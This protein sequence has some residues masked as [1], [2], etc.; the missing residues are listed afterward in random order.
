M[1]YGIFVIVMVFPMQYKATK[2]ANILK[3]KKKTNSD[4]GGVLIVYNNFD[5]FAPCVFI[6][7][8]T[9]KKKCSTTHHRSQYVCEEHNSII[10][11]HIQ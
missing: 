6:A 7:N 8:M 1:K 4:E 9:G 11:F 2:S 3:K 5:G 10:S